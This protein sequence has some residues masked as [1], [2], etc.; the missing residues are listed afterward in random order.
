M[1]VDDRTIIT[2]ETMTGRG[3]LRLGALRHES[4]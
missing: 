2:K 1:N 4:E 3:Q